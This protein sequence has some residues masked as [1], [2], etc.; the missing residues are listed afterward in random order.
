MSGPPGDSGRLYFEWWTPDPVLLLAAAQ[1]V[2][3]TQNR[4]VAPVW[5]CNELTVE[6]AW[7]HDAP[8]RLSTSISRASAGKGSFVSA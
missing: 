5:Y 8:P 3:G 4:V 1:E 6:G 2:S 7:L